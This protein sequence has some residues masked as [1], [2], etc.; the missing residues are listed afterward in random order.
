MKY[1]YHV[2]IHHLL[3]SQT[4]INSDYITIIVFQFFSVNFVSFCVHEIFHFILSHFITSCVTVSVAHTRGVFT[5]NV[6]ET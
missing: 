2:S 3:I 1:V 5:K 6:M 4:I